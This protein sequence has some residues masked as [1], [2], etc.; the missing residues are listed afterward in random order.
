MFA[1]RRDASRRSAYGCMC[2]PR[3]TYPSVSESPK[4]RMRG[5][6]AG[7]EAAA[8]SAGVATSPTCLTSR[9]RDADAMAGCGCLPTMTSPVQPR[10]TEL[11]RPNQLCLGAQRLSCSGRQRRPFPCSRSEQF[12]TRPARQGSRSVAERRGPRR[13]EGTVPTPLRHARSNG[14]VTTAKHTTDNNTSAAA[15]AHA[16]SH[17][18]LLSRPVCKNPDEQT[19]PE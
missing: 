9:D 13:R 3:S 11:S 1:E 19:Q 18:E 8:D 10:Q 7:E 16:S 14:D 12:D 17:L 4:Q 15:M 6:G 5:T 2:M